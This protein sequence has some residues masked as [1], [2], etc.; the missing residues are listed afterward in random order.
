MAAVDAFYR[1][2]CCLLENMPFLAMVILIMKS[3]GSLAYM[4]MTSFSLLVTYAM[5][6]IS[7]FGLYAE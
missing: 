7:S 1:L 4:L 2:M 3:N 5:P 6:N